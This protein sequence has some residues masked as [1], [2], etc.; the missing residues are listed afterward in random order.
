M[1]Y[2]GSLRGVGTSSNAF[3]SDVREFGDRLIAE[4]TGLRDGAEPRAEEEDPVRAD[5]L[6]EELRRRFRETQVEQLWSRHTAE[7]IAETFERLGEPRGEEGCL[8]AVLSTNMVSVGL[9]VSRLALM[10]VNG[11]PLTTGEY[12]QATSRVGRDEVPG[13]VVANYYR[14]Q[15]RSLSHY[16]SFRPYHESFYRFVEPSSVTPYTFQVRKRAL[17]AALVIALRHAC[18]GLASNKAA[19]NF[20]QGSPEVRRVVTELTRRV[21]R[22]CPEKAEEVQEHMDRLLEEWHN[23]VER[24]RVSAQGLQYRAWDNAYS[25]LLYSHEDRAGSP[26]ALDD[27]EL[28]AERRESGGAGD[29]V[30]R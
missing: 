7:Q 11:Q 24:C 2:H 17:H 9:D 19:V 16:E 3:Q 20:D 6:E 29:D 1:V 21:R 30:R 4:Y 5:P 25:R 26:W 8:D 14:S 28:D 23:E 18:N 22:A 15:A 12:V 27:P 10:V 13:V